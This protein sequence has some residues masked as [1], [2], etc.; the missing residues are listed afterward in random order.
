[1]SDPTLSDYCFKNEMNWVWTTLWHPTKS[2]IDAKKY[3]FSWNEK[4]SLVHIRF[5]ILWTFI[6]RGRRKSFIQTWSKWFRM[7]QTTH[8]IAWLFSTPYDLRIMIHE[9]WVISIFSV[10]FTSLITVI[11]LSYLGT[12]PRVTS[13]RNWNSIFHL[14]CINYALFP[15]LSRLIGQPIR[16]RKSS[17]LVRVK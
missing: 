11:L 3:T 6:R 7:S 15:Q 4:S 13:S 17:F 16:T 1:M 14:C 10:S 8:D 12:V 2:R 9:L 5:R